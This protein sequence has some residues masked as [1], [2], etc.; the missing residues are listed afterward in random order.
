VVGINRFWLY[1]AAT[2]VTALLVLPFLRV[3]VLFDLE[4]AGTVL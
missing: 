2:G 4:I 3:V 1:L